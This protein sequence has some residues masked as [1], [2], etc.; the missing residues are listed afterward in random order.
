M[1]AP[2]ILLL[3][4]SACPS[5]TED[6]D[7]EEPV[8]PLQQV[9]P[10]GVHFGTV[11]VG[12]AAPDIQVTLSNPGDAPLDVY[13]IA[14]TTEASGFELGTVGQGQRI[15]AGSAGTF[16]VRYLPEQTGSVTEEL[17]ITSNVT[18]AE[19]PRVLLVTAEV[20][21][22]ALA[23]TPD[24]ISVDAAVSASV[25]VVLRNPGQADLTVENITIEGD[26]G[27]GIDL[28]VDRN[29]VLPFEL[30]PSDP[31]SGLPSITVV[32]TWSPEASDGSGA[33][34]LVLESDAWGDER[35]VL[36]LSAPAR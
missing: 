34:E 11:P 35:L 17:A 3:L 19:A 4:L 30:P 14:F 1:R 28:R 31:D 2:W 22:A 10:G 12:E 29:G 27:F 36:P 6:T 9:E 26:P 16:V 13:D 15:R 24:R 20:V 23:V 33:A 5:S 25:D 32:V 18:P 8:G 21:A 7:P